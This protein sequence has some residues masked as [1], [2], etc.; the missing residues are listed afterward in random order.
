MPHFPAL[1]RAAKTGT[2][3]RPTTAIGGGSLSQRRF[4]ITPPACQGVK[5]S[6]GRH[7]YEGP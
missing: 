3:R 6:G 2:D 7:G 4:P 1:I 5:P